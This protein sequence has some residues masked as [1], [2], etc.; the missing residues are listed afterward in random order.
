MRHHRGHGDNPTSR[1]FTVRC[2]A[3]GCRDF[4]AAFIN[5]CRRLLLVNARRAPHV[6]KEIGKDTYHEQENDSFALRALL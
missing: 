2:L 3:V 1:T 4:R 5:V 6:K